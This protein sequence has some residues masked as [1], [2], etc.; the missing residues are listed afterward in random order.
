MV[1]AFWFGVRGRR[2]EK[3]ALFQVSVRLDVEVIY[4]T[5]SS[6]N[7][8]L[9]DLPT[10]TIRLFGWRRCRYKNILLIELHFSKLN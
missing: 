4:S 2:V 5:K 8:N 9:I 1:Y 3:A 6:F 7:N 10:Q